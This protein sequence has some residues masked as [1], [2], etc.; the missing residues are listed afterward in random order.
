MKIALDISPIKTGH[1][2]RGIG[3]YTVNLVEE[4]QKHKDQVE[5]ELFENPKSP[6]PADTIHYPYFDLFSHT[7]PIRTN[8]SRVVTI[9]DVIPLV[10][11]EYFPA[12]VKG[13]LSFF[14]QKMALA[15]VDAVICDSESSRSD[16]ISK[17]SYPKEKIHVIYLAPG[18]NFQR[19][20]DSKYLSDVTKRF[21][22]PKTFIL[23]V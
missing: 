19:I 22:L 4:L 3:S 6:P 21:K 23:Y 12:G 2:V 18:S 5:L 1:K 17:L 16:I 14:F 20:E 11:P 13:Y 7:L 8:K 9:H 10:F 15:N